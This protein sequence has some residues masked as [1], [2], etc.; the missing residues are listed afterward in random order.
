M[1]CYLEDDEACRKIWSFIPN[2]LLNQDVILRINGVIITEYW[3]MQNDGIM[4]NGG[5]VSKVIHD[6]IPQSIPLHMNS[7]FNIVHGKDEYEFRLVKCYLSDEAL[8]D[9]WM[10]DPRSNGDVEYYPRENGERSA[11]LE[12]RV[13]YL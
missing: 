11:D 7:I 2:L 6:L 9:K 13:C 5:N 4:Q 12:K 3:W 1:S 8:T 10:T